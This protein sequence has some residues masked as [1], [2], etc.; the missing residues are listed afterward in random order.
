[1]PAVQPNAKMMPA[2][3][4]CQLI[5]RLTELIVG[6]HQDDIREREQEERPGIM[7]ASHQSDGTDRTYLLKYCQ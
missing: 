1:M 6:T 2:L 7:S 4:V 5:I 3:E